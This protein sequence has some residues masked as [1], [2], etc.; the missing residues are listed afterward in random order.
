VYYALFE[1]G[2]KQCFT[3]LM[4]TFCLTYVRNIVDLYNAVKQKKSNVLDS[5]NYKLDWEDLEK[6][7]NEERK[8][9]LNIFNCFQHLSTADCPN[10]DCKAGHTT[11]LAEDQF[12]KYE[13]IM[14]GEKNTYCRTYYPGDKKKIWREIQRVFQKHRPFDSFKLKQLL[15]K[16]PKDPIKYVDM[17]VKYLR[18]HIEETDKTS[19]FIGYA[20]VRSA[21]NSDFPKFQAKLPDLKACDTLQTL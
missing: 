18:I 6:H 16:D 5:E 19:P 12:E 10:T 17:Y 15:F 4:S 13:Q 1:T 11:V 20:Y 14:A 3:K 9:Q 7:L 21:N 8:K 2:D